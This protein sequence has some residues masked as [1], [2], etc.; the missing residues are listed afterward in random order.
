MSRSHFTYKL[1]P[2]RPSFAGDMTEAEAAVMG[3]HAEYWT[4]HFERGTVVVFG[5]VLDQSG[6]WG[7]SVVEGGGEEDV[8]ALAAGDPAVATGMCTY[9]VG[10]MP[11]AMVRPR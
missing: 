1:I 7:L 2:P 11:Q 8:H 10:T 3:Q 9:E 5:V 4:D 6:C